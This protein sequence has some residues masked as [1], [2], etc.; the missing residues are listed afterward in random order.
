MFARNSLLK[1]LNLNSNKIRK[2]DSNTFRGMRLLRR[3][4]LSNNRINDVGRGTFSTVTR[5]GTVDLSKNLIKKIDYQMFYQLQ[6]AEVNKI[7]KKKLSFLTS[8]FSA[9]IVI[10]LKT[11]SDHRRVG[12]PGDCGGKAGLQGPVLG[13]GQS[14]P[15]R[16]HE[17]R[18]R[19]LRE[20]R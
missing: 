7:K 1:V 20:L 13:E 4:Y 8:F 19:S 17:D 11:L 10:S 6:Y 18:E 15:Q 2:L 14:L 9:Q 16:D 5:I 3:L 12:E